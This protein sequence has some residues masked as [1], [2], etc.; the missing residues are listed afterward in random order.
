MRK[1]LFLFSALACFVGL[2]AIFVVDGY[3]GIYDTIYIKAGEYEQRIEPD[4]FLEQD[5]FFPTGVSW[6]EK[7]FFRYEVNNR[8][9][10]TYSP[11][12]TVSVWHENNKINNLLST[13]TVVEPFAMATIEWTLDSME[14]ESFGFTEGNYTVII[15]RDEVERRIIVDYHVEYPPKPIIIR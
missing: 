7:V 9:F 12:I 15:E 13:D 5:R 14:L 4:R 11:T 3:M 1:N 6:G 10:S 8:K 2:I